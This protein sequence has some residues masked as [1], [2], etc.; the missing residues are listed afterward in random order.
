[1]SNMDMQALRSFKIET[2]LDEH[3]TLSSFV[4]REVVTTSLLRCWCVSAWAL[5]V[6]ALLATH[7]ST[8]I[9]F[10]V[11]KA[12]VA[13]FWIVDFFLSYYGVIYKMRRLKVRA[14]INQAADAPEEELETWITPANP[15][16]GLGRSDKIGAVRATLTSPAVQGVY[17]VIIVATLILALTVV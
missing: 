9:A 5:S 14:W 17:V 2:L 11:I 8:L 12:L 15:F 1:M 6:I 3:R 4:E 13:S 10:I 16:D 7:T